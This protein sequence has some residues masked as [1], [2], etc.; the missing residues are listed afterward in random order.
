MQ[1]EPGSPEERFSP[2]QRDLA[3]STALP[4]R[5]R[6]DD[7][8]GRNMTWDVHFVK[9]T[10][11][12]NTDVLQAGL[13]GAPEGFTV[14]AEEQKA[15]R[16]RMN[17]SWFSPP[18][19]GLYAS[20]LVRP[21]ISIG[22]AGLLSFC[23]ANAMRAAIAEAGLET[24]RIK[25][26]NDLVAGGKKICGILSSC[27]TQE[28]RLDFAVIGLGVNL[29]PGSYP[30]ELKDRAGCLAEMGVTPDREDL[31]YQYL[32]HLDRQLRDLEAGGAEVL[33]EL[34]DHCVTLGREVLVSGG[35]ELRGTAVDIGKS[36][37]LILRTEDGKRMPVLAGDVSVRGI[38]GYA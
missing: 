24:V 10:G 17:R 18:G 15:G 6:T 1:A 5:I 29:G 27:R 9:V 7:G 28:G 21:R 12:T 35:T 38:M 30:E 37:E 22:E 32:R 23:A 36:G 34:K 14:V 16:G 31:L 3:D 33:A 2:A 8:K 13:Q 26:P 25:W 11:S 19:A 20:V 4:G